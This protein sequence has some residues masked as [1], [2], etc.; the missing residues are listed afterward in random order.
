MDIGIGLPNSVR[1]VD[2]RGI[3]DW[4]RQAEQAGA[5]EVICSPPRPTPRRS[6][7]WPRRSRASRRPRAGDESGPRCGES[8]PIYS[9]PFPAG[10]PICDAYRH[11]RMSCRAL[12]LRIAARSL[13]PA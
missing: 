11:A 3:V 9:P 12:C 4:A 13:A 10:L 6:S 2:R 7:F 8:N 1:G 5:D